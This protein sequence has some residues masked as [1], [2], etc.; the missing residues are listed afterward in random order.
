MVNYGKIINSWNAK[1][2]DCLRASVVDNYWSWAKFFQEH[3]LY[4]I[5]YQLTKHQE[6]NFTSPDIKESVFLKSSLGT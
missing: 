2:L 3:F 5:L 1:F 4:I 6:Q